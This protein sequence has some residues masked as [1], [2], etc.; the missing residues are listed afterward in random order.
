MVSMP[1]TTSSRGWTRRFVVKGL[2]FLVASIVG[3]VAVF[4]RQGSD[5]REVRES[6]AEIIRSLAI[7][8]ADKDY[9]LDHLGPIHER[10]FSDSYSRRYRGTPSEFDAVRYIHEVFG[11]LSDVAY[12]DKHLILASVLRETETSLVAAQEAE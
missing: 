8:D 2:A 9:C 1:H 11:P 7:S 10:A 4:Q 5:N 3:I 12:A 6:T